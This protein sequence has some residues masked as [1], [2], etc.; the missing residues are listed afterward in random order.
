MNKC[1]NCETR[2][3]PHEANASGYGHFTREGRLC[4][5]GVRRDGGTCSDPRPVV[6]ETALARVIGHESWDASSMEGA[7]SLQS[8]DLR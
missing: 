3:A 4:Y 2:V 6:A 1:V 8:A 5:V 7:L